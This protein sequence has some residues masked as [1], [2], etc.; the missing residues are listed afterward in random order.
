MLAWTGTMII[1]LPIEGTP[2][3]I[4]VISGIILLAILIWLAIAIRQYVKQQQ[5]SQNLV[6]EVMGKFIIFAIAL[7]L[8][9]VFVLDRDLT[10]AARF[11]FFYFPAVILF[12]AGMFAHIWRGKSRSKKYLV[13]VTL[14]VSFAGGLSVINNYV[15]Q[16]PDRPDL[17]VPV[18]REAQELNP[19]VETLVAIVHKTHEQTG[20]VMGIAWEY[21]KLRSQLQPQLEAENQDSL[22]IPLFLLLHKDGDENSHLV[23]ESLH[24][25]IASLSRPLDVWVVNFAVSAKLKSQGCS[26]DKNFKRRVAGYRFR[27][28]HCY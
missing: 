12:M 7:I 19:E 15:Y 22:K 28:F 18:M 26:S 6:T 14:L 20:E 8:V 25:N 21:N 13:I 27:L 9:F 5:S 10:L 1:L 11:Q 16:K 17:V 2:I 4:T 23:T 24:R 3:W